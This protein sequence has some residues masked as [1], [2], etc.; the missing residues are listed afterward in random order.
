MVLFHPTP[1][2]AIQ[3]ILV[4]FFFSVNHHWALKQE[5]KAD[6]VLEHFVP[7]FAV[8]SSQNEGYP[9]DNI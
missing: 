8:H 4:F 1:F 9:E 5:T 6:K 3:K 2:Q 7:L